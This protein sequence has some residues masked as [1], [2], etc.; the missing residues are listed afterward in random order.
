MIRLVE[1]LPGKVDRIFCRI[2]IVDLNDLSRAATGAEQST[3]YE[4]LSYTWDVQTSYE[5][6]WRND[7]VLP[8]TQNLYVALQRL[9]K[10]STSSLYWI[11]AI[12]INQVDI[13]ERGDHVAIMRIIYHR[14][15]HVIA[16]IGPDDQY[17]Q[18]AFGLIETIVAKRYTQMV[19]SKLT[20][21]LSGIIT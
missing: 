3:S 16:W 11:D 5:H 4:A 18:K 7:K 21:V 14:A 6:V 13:S 15:V 2:H 8:V 12:C 17:T 1:I 9:R 10:P 20:P 19:I